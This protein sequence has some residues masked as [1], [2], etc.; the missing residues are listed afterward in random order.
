MREKE[1]E[2][3]KEKCLER[4]RKFAENFIK[5]HKLKSEDI[6]GTPLWN[7]IYRNV[8]VKCSNLYR[9]ME[10]GLNP[11]YL[12]GLDYSPNIFYSPA[13]LEINL[14]KDLKNKA[15]NA[16][17]LKMLMELVDMEKVEKG[18]VEKIP[19]GVLVNLVSN[20]IEIETD[21]E[22]RKKLTQLL[23]KLSNLSN[24]ESY[25]L[26]KLL[27]RMLN[28]DGNSVKETVLR[29]FDEK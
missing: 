4:L 23:E 24:T 14:L 16:E 5:K 9:T 29:V 11:L 27:L 26:F 22:K 18:I 19:K 20:E 15:F 12:F 21:K 6:K 2:I 3:F 8:D 7:F 13:G 28:D 25:V 10:Y 17:D 1:K